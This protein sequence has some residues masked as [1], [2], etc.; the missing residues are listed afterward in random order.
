MTYD[1]SLWVNLPEDEINSVFAEMGRSGRRVVAAGL[2]DWER[3]N[4]ERWWVI[5]EREREY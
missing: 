5:V 3:Y 1:T 2:H 4:A